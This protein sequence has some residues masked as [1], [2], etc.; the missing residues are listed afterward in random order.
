ML[1][2]D[3]MKLE[4]LQPNFVLKENGL[5]QKFPKLIQKLNGELDRIRSE[6]GIINVKNK[7]LF[8]Q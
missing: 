3:Q 8:I 7:L 2:K 1:P 5:A 6:F 4:E